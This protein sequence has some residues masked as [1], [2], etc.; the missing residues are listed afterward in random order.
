M[1]HP[2]L[3]YPLSFSNFFF[4]VF[5]L[6]PLIILLTQA[7]FSSLVLS[8]HFFFFEHLFLR[9]FLY[10]ITDV[11]FFRFPL[12]LL[13][14]PLGITLARNTFFFFFCYYPFSC[15]CHR[16]LLHTHLLSLS[17][18]PSSPLVRFFIHHLHL[19]LSAKPK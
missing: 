9:F 18:S 5:F 15:K 12:Y 14:S 4:F 10:F 2:Y 13:F 6:S 3:Y 8:R 1:S 11:L 7:C 16:A 19:S 17:L